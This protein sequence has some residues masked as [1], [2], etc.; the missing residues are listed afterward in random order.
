ML[1]CMRR[2]VCLDGLRGV[3]A[4][5]VMLSHMLP[6]APL[7]GWLGRA[8]SHGGA[9]VDVFFILS[10]LVIVQSLASFEYQP[11]P[12]LIAR[13]ARIYPVFLVVFAV[14]VAVQPL[15]SGFSL[16]SWIDQDSTLRY[17]W[18]SGWPS[19]WVVGVATH[20]TMTHG[21]FPDGARPDLWLGFL[22]AAWSLSTEWQFYLLAVLVGARIGLRPLCWMF[23]AVS[24]GSM[25]WH[26]LAP[27]AWQFSRAFLPNKAQYFALG[28]ASALVV[29]QGA[30]GLGTY[31]AVL[32]VALA[33]S[34]VQ[35]GIDKL[36]P[37]VIWSLCLAAQ[38]QSSSPPGFAGLTRAAGSAL[39]LLA[40]TLRSRPLVW[41]GAVSY[42]IYLVNEPVQKVLG[43]ALA[44]VVQGNATLFTALWLPGAATLPI[45]AAWAL[46]VW[47]EAPALR[48]GRAL[49]RRSMPAAAAPVSAG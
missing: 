17:L 8:F 9:G 28:I 40:A 29:R 13:V 3:L 35:G 39:G 16:M 1:C 19:D 2:M 34:A 14:S 48:R 45:L 6:F 38:L 27:E 10:G 36:L 31:W 5:Y 22:G 37:P 41:L 42:G 32:A 49:A 30:K 23:L 25:V 4:F 43:L 47:V 15:A 46:H 24:V 26:A 33:L 11:R 44:L 7:P 20:L 12:F 21:L 18:P